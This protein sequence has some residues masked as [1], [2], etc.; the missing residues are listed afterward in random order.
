MA[1]DCNTYDCLTV[2]QQYAECLSTVTL[3]LTAA[4]TGTWSWQYEFN[5]RWSGGT[6]DVTDGQKVVLPWVF[7]EQYVHEI[8]FY[9]ANGGLVNDTCYKLDTSKISGSY[10]APSASSGTSYLTFIVTAAMLSNEGATITNS[11]I[12]SRTIIIVQD[13]NSGYNSGSYTQA[14]N[15]F[16]MTNSTTFYEGQTL[17]LIFG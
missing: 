9:D 6:V 12:T 10:S 8:K 2:V 5:G 1:C 11:S 14:S 4:E 3:N 15:S 17:T 7:N 13:E 16:T